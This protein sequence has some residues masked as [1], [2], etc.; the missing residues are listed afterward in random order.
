[1]LV[2]TGRVFVRQEHLQILQENGYTAPRVEKLRGDSGTGPARFMFKACWEATWEP[3]YRLY[4]DDSHRCLIDDYRATHLKVPPRKLWVSDIDQQQPV[5]LE[6]GL[7]AKQ[8]ACNVYHEGS[9]ERLHI[10][11]DPINPDLD[12]HST[13][14]AVK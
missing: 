9:K 4:H 10:S 11:I 1:M 12:I 5:L 13:G 14:V 8:A 2:T 6:Q 7:N 3:E